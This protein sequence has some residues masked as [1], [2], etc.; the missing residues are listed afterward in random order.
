MQTELFRCYDVRQRLRTQEAADM[1]VKLPPEIAGDALI[2]A[3]ALIPRQA[4]HGRNLP[5]QMQKDVFHG[6]LVGTPGQKVIAQA[7][8]ELYAIVQALSDQVDRAGHLKV[9]LLDMADLPLVCGE[10]MY[11]SGEGAPASPPTVPFQE[12]YDSTN[13]KFYKAKGVLPDIPTVG[14]WLALN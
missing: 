4:G 2:G 11:I 14:D 10:K 3:S 12:Y 6:N 9:E 7:F 8:A 1:F 13:L 5:F